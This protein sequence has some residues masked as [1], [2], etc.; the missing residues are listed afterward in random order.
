MTLVSKG[1]FS[2][3]RIMGGR[4]TSCL[5]NLGLKHVLENETFVTQSTDKNDSMRLLSYI[6]FKTEIFTS[7]G[8][9][10]GC[11]RFFFKLRWWSSARTGGL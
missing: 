11:F 4:V 6:S 3:S 5:K 2:T 8:A 7:F 1:P 10:V 9:K